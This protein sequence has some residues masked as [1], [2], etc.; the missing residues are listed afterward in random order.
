MISFKQFLLEVFSR[1]Q[2]ETIKD[3]IQFAVRQSEMS[4]AREIGKPIYF[5]RSGTG[6]SGFVFA[7][8]MRRIGRIETVGTPTL[9]KPINP[10]E[11]IKV[12]VNPKVLNPKFTYYLFMKLHK[13]EV[14]R[15]MANGVTTKVTIP[16][17]ELKRL[18]FV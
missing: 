5:T 15:N 4:R 3:Q 2:V 6:P 12:F 7:F 11:W 10:E 13:E 17:R 18:K 8:W 14:F 16:L 9:E 1:A